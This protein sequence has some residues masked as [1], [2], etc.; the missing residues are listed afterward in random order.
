LCLW[1]PSDRAGV[2]LCGTFLSGQ[3]LV[4]ATRNN[5]WEWI[6][7]L[8]VNTNLCSTCLSNGEGSTYVSRGRFG[9]FVTSWWSFWFSFCSVVRLKK[10][11]TLQNWNQILIFK[12]RTLRVP[13]IHFSLPVRPAKLGKRSW[14]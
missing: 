7:V 8:I 11:T 5:A 9:E 4:N 14:F 6:Q 2:V 10:R 12:L 1:L 3:A 13:F